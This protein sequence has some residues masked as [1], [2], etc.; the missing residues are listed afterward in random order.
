VKTISLKKVS[1]VA[2]ASLGIGLLSVVPAQAALSTLADE[3]ANLTV[4][5]A[6]ST[7][8]VAVSGSTAVV[9]PAFVGASATLTATK[10][11]TVVGTLLTKPVGATNPTIA[12][13]LTGAD[14]GVFVAE[15]TTTA[16]KSQSEVYSTT[17]IRTLANATNGGTL[18]TITGGVGTKVGEFT[19]TGFDK[20]GIYTFAITPNGAGTDTAATVTVRAGFSLDSTNPNRAFPTQ[21]SNITTGW[22]A[23]AGGQATVRITGFTDATTYYY[24]TNNGSIVS[25]TRSASTAG[26]VTAT[27][28]IN[29]S[30]GF[31]H[32]TAS[33][34]ASDYIDVTLA[35]TGSPTSTT[36]KVVSYDATTGA[37]TTF[38]TATVTW[39]VAA[40]PT[41]QYSLVK[42][43]AGADSTNV[44]SSTTDT[45]DTVVS[46]AT[47]AQRF[48]IQVEVMDQYN[49]DF[50]GATLAASISGPGT[51]GIAASRS[52][53]TQ[54]GRS[55]SVALTGQNYGSVSV[56]GDGSAG[57]ATVTITA[58]TATSTVTL[59]TKTVTFAGSPSK[60]AVTQALYVARAGYELGRTP[61]TTSG[62]A[63]SVATTPAFYAEV[64]D[65]NGAAV[66]AGSTV[67]MTSSDPTVITVGTCAEST[68]SALP[69]TF[70][71]SVSG[72]SGAASGKTA[73]VTFSVLNSTTGLYDI[74]ASPLTFTIGGAIEKVVVTV[75]K[76]SYTAG[77]GV[78]L[79]ATATD[80]SGNKA[81]DGQ[82]WQLSASTKAASNKSM[83]GTLPAETKEIKNGKQSTTSSTGT[84]SLFAPSTPGSFSIAGTYAATTAAPLGTAWSV[85]SAVAD[86]NVAIITQIDALNA[87]IVALNALIAKIM[88]KLGVK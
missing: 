26:T 68:A 24:T 41:A 3:P 23:T 55:L 54:T 58:S 46:R 88:K 13:A 18:A 80:A 43:L 50:N 81:Y 63:T 5:A 35:D 30:Q 25:G 29:L 60:V 39:G 70:E 37:A 62:A 83:G 64:T 47:T 79:T 22:A 10:G 33:S 51:I 66:V 27:N 20:P 52:A 6:S 67:K 9:V 72:A 15:A 69:G 4:F 57:K 32:L 31:Y 65:S 85:T 75:D 38:V 34:T 45:T 87:K 42:L 36:V 12:A 44:T 11:F 19:L 48:T 1:A 28:A 53:T 7:T 61:T 59:G 14:S 17:G 84:A 71:C 73:T 8:P 76:T 56:W 77:E 2:V 16:S 40:T 21:G 82:T 49:V 74:V 78:N 86:G